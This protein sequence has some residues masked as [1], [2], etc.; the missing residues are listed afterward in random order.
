MGVEPIR[1]FQR[2][3]AMPADDPD[4]LHM[5]NS[6]AVESAAAIGKIVAQI[7]TERFDQAVRLIADAHSIAVAGQEQAHAIAACLGDGLF[8]MGRRCRTLHA[9]DHDER[10]HVAA[11]TERDVLVA[12]SY[13]PG[14]CPVADLIPIARNRRARILG[15]TDSSASPVAHDADLNL[16]LETDRRLGVQPLAPYFVLV[17]SLLMALDEAQRE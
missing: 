13:G 5:L 15:I 2:I 12:I 9:I 7:S 4:P 6:F 17:Q 8:R 16:I 3:C 10:W 14:H 11:L 1:L